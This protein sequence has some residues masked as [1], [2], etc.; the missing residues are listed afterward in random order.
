[1]YMGLN[2]FLENFNLPRKIFEGNF[3]MEVQHSSW[4]GGSGLMKEGLAYEGKSS[5]ECC[6]GEILHI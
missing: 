1:M 4:M 5:G 2:N 6:G 3:L